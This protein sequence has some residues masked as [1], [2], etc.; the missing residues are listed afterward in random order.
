MS[1]TPDIFYKLDHFSLKEKKDILYSAN[2]LSYKR[3]IE[4][5]DCEESFTRQKSNLSFDEIM[6]KCTD[7]CHFVFIRRIHVDRSEY[8][9][10][11]FC[12]ISQTPEYFLFL[13][14]T[15]D[16]LEYLI[17]KYKLRTMFM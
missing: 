8:G 16:D 2:L 14:V 7:E 6:S 9:E 13:Y 10:I 5:L 11:G 12:T 15:I 17:D 4:F 3:F 1:Y